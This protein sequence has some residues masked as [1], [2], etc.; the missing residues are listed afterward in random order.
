MDDIIG[1]SEQEAW[2]LDSTTARFRTA[3]ATLPRYEAGK[4]AEGSPMFPPSEAGLSVPIL[5]VEDGPWIRASDLDTVLAS[6][7]PLAMIRCCKWCNFQENTSQAREL[8]VKM[9]GEGKHE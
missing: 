3:I 1:T 7:P 8:C 5:H 6:V 4:S 9:T 2:R